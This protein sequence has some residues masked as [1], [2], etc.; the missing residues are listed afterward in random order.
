MNVSTPCCYFLTV[1]SIL[2]GARAP[3]EHRA[4]P[5]DLSS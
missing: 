4:M 1:I 2:A 5:S 3:F